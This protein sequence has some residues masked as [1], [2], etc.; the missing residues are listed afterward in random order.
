MFV[1]GSEEIG[2]LLLHAVIYIVMHYVTACVCVCLYVSVCLFLF[3]CIYS[4]K[5]M[6]VLGSVFLFPLLSV[7]SFG[8]A[9]YS[10][11]PFFSRASLCCV[12]AYP[13]C[14][15]VRASLPY[16]QRILSLL[17]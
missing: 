5:C 8:F 11:L 17:Q 13:L 15:C 16:V 2:E 12:S 1:A 14:L 10:F 6:C 7:L 3:R 9:L 4:C